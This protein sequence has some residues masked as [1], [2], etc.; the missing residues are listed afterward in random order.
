MLKMHTC[1][2]FTV[3]LEIFLQSRDSYCYLFY[4]FKSTAN[5]FI[6]NSDQKLSYKLCYNAIYGKLD[7]N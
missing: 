7:R 4:F 5:G 1:S 6:I 2:A 3:N